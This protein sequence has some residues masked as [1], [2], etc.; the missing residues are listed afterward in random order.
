MLE[1]LSLTSRV[2][3]EIL[4]QRIKEENSYY[5]QKQRKA[6]WIGHILRGTS[7]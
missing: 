7:D 4:L 5:L 6:K 2:K 3:N 1:N